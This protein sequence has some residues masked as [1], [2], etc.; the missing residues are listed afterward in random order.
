[1]HA[2]SHVPN[3]NLEYGTFSDMAGVDQMAL[4]H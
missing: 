4:L 2:I 1:M 3:H